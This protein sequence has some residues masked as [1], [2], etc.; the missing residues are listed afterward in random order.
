MVRLRPQFL[1]ARWRTALHTL[2]ALPFIRP[3]AHTAASWSERK[4]GI[5]SSPVAGLRPDVGFKAVFVI[6]GPTW[7]FASPL[8]IALGHG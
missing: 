3:V 7:R 2:T 5:R 1:R 6:K 8:Q 4:G